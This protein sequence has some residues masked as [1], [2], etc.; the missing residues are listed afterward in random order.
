MTAAGYRNTSSPRLMM[1]FTRDALVPSD[2]GFTSYTDP[3]DLRNTLLSFENI[4]FGGD[5]TGQILVRLINPQ[6]EIEKKIFSWYCSVNPRAWAASQETDSEN[7]QLSATETANIFIRWGYVAPST[8]PLAEEDPYALSEIHRG[9]IIDV[10]YEV[11]DNKD[12]IVTLRIVNF[13]D[14]SIE[15]NQQKEDYTEESVSLVKG[16]D[17]REPSKVISEVFGILAAGEGAQSV[18][19][20]SDAHKSILDAEFLKVH[21][22]PNKK[23]S[24]PA[25]FEN[26]PHTDR[27]GLSSTASTAITQDV[28]QTFYE[29]LGFNSKVNSTLIKYKGK[30]LPKEVQALDQNGSTGID[31]NIA[32][33]D[34]K[35]Y[36][37]AWSEYIKGDSKRVRYELPTS[38]VGKNLN[39]SSFALAEFVGEDASSLGLCYVFDI[40]SPV[41][42]N[43]KTSYTLDWQPIRFKKAS[44]SPANSIGILPV[45][46]VKGQS[47]G[48]INP[49][50]INSFIRFWEQLPIEEQETYMAY[51]TSRATTIGST[52]TQGAVLIYRYSLKN[53]NERAIAR[54]SDRLDRQSF[55][56]KAQVLDVKL[57]ND[58]QLQGY[59]AIYELSGPGIDIRNVLIAGEF[60]ED[61][62]GD[63]AALEEALTNPPPDTNKILFKYKDKH[64]ALRSTLNKLNKKFFDK[65]DQYLGSTQ[66]FCNAVPN[67]DREFIANYL[68]IEVEWETTPYITVIGTSDFIEGIFPAKSKIKSFPIELENDPATISIATGF[69]NRK[70]NIITDL[71]YRISKAGFYYDILKAPII[72]QQLYSVIKRFEENK[73]YLDLVKESVTL[74]ISKGGTDR[75][76]LN[77]K[78]KE[79]RSYA[80]RRLVS[81]GLG[82]V[83]GIQS[84][85][86][87]MVKKFVDDSVQDQFEQLKEDLSFINNNGFLDIFFPYTS[88]EGLDSEV[89]VVHTDEGTKKVESRVREISSS[90][91]STLQTLMK[92]DNEAT[93]VELAVKARVLASFKNRISD[94]EV[95][96]LGVPEM[97][98]LAFETHNRNVALWVSEPRV[99]GTFH[100]L[101][102]IYHIGGLTHKIDTSGYKTTLK[103]IPSGSSNTT[104]E[105][106]KAQ[107]SFL[108]DD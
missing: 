19:R 70:D 95:E 90:P 53:F 3:F 27:V 61:F 85:A 1:D 58:N 20:F 96:I 56:R 31:D 18:V 51:R 42:R 43:G 32:A 69:N 94:I 103:L 34:R 84:D 25:Q 50:S 38:L 30:V 52:L 13:H 67:E 100:W 11:S 82:L 83:T 59:G 16:L 99:P 107:Y 44:T 89:K 102:G 7:W 106:L 14:L 62:G 79:D 77:D 29:S 26:T 80:A 49:T 4:V 86:P 105:M 92:V 6:Q 5:D 72:E 21:P 8:T 36:E 57:G 10:G 93:A 41:T 47:G 48:P 33:Q 40:D 45:S 64:K 101:S 65:A 98:I 54:I 39:T 37:Y 15:R 66:I 73:D 68:G 74:S 9:Q 46:R 60:D 12:R 35:K 24:A 91:L 23:L 108:R 55:V 28:I 2:R 87:S 71:R 88:N 81:N 97:D 78:A 104:E 22:G 17:L 76:E 63:A 75:L